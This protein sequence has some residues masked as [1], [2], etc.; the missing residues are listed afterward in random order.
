MS[1]SCPPATPRPNGSVPSP[2]PQAGRP[3]ASTTQ[4]SGLAAPPRH[5]WPLPAS[6]I[7]HPPI[8]VETLHL[9]SFTGAPGF[10]AMLSNAA[11][12][13]TDLGATDIHTEVLP[14]P[15]VRRWSA[16]IRSTATVAAAGQSV[17]SVQCNYLAGS[18]ARYAGRLIVHNVSVITDHRDALAP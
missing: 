5:D 18:G 7:R 4:H 3:S 8:A 2:C 10:R 6:R 17:W 13:F 11:V 14:I 9:F 1:A 15:P 16:A 12:T